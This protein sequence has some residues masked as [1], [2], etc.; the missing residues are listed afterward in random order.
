MMNQQT[1]ILHRPWVLV[2]TLFSVSLGFS[3]LGIATL[4]SRPVLAAVLLGIA[5]LFFFLLTLP[6]KIRIYVDKRSNTLIAATARWYRLRYSFDSRRLSDI[7]GITQLFPVKPTGNGF[8]DITEAGSL[9]I[10]MKHD[11]T[12]LTIFPGNSAPLGVSVDNI[13]QQIARFLDISFEQYAMY[14]GYL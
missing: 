6:R 4:Q 7:C 2:P 9:I 12:N 5:F 11:S 1:L 14:E 13:G 8:T 3:F 10:A